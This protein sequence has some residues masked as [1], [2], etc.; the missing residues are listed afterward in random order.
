M[1]MEMGDGGQGDEDGEHE[2]HASGVAE[3][4]F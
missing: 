3:W 2:V 1:K 4:K